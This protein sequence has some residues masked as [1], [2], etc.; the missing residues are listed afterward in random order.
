[1]ELIFLPQQKVSAPTRHIWRRMFSP[2]WPVMWEHP[3]LQHQPPTVKGCF[4]RY[5]STPQVTVTVR[6]G[7]K[8]KWLCFGRPR[9]VTH[10]LSLLWHVI[11]KDGSVLV[12]MISLVCQVVIL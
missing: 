11:A 9:M 5:H 7:L 4:G 10:R 2:L 3:P 6:L 12:L 1:M 8:A